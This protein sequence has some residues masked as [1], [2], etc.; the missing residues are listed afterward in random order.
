ME[1][2]KLH[3]SKKSNDSVPALGL[4]FSLGTPSNKTQIAVEITM[5]NERRRI[6]FIPPDKLAPYNFEINSK[7]FRLELG[8]IKE[9]SIKGVDTM[10]Y[11]LSITDLSDTN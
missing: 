11:T 5:N 3:L 1:V 9:E 7:Y 6:Q 4:M 8:S 2:F 10:T